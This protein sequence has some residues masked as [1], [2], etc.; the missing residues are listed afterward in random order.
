MIP[1][2]QSRI[3]M[4]QKGIEITNKRRV[5]QYGKLLD[6]ILDNFSGANL[7]QT[8]KNKKHE[9]FSDPL[10]AVALYESFRTEI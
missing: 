1:I 8:I 3:T 7:T 4:K 6:Y 5:L 10:L 9:Y 2:Y